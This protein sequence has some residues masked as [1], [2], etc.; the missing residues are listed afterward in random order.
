MSIYKERA[1]YFD[2]GY[3]LASAVLAVGSTVITTTGAT[4][5]GIEIVAGDTVKASITIYDNSLTAVGNILSRV[6]V[7]SGESVLRD[8][9]IPVIARNGIYIVAAG[10]ELSGAVFYGPKG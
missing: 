8:R 7:A 6:I 10:S 4:Y 3:G 9:Q 5:H 2:V 1:D